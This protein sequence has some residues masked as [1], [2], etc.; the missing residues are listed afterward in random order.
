M[1]HTIIA[2]EPGTYTVTYTLPG[3]N[4]LV[5]E[6]IVLTSGFTASV[7]VQL[8]VG[9][10]QESVTVS[11]ARPVADI[12]NASQQA[13]MTREIME[14]IPTGKSTTSSGLLI[15]PGPTN[16]HAWPLRQVRVPD[17][18]L[19]W[20][21]TREG[22]E[23]QAMKTRWLVLVSLV[24]LASAP[25]AGQQPSS[26]PRLSDQQKEGRRLYQQKCALCHLPILPAD[27]SGDPYAPRLGKSLV[28]ANEDYV[29]RVIADGTGP[30]M[31]GWKYTLQADQIDA[32][33][34]YLRTI[35]TASRTVG[36]QPSELR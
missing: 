28:D 10:V 16:D 21:A 15:L 8:S 20:R 22:M 34:D 2:L 13:V 24:C 36:V 5:R 6:G 18:L 35:E 23:G 3:F 19:T 29:R 30:R 17:R 9:D 32:L 12:Q 33:V 27:G 14:E 4:T 26:Q 7:D 1:N 31:P 25:I 11:G